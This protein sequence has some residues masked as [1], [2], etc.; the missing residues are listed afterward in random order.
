LESGATFTI[1]KISYGIGVE[2]VFPLF[3]PVI[4]KIEILRRGKVRRAKLYYI[5]EKA[6]RE[7]RRKMRQTTYQEKAVVEA[8]VSEEVK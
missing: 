3:S 8:P 1:R 7:T 5:R 6:A 4:D 2:R